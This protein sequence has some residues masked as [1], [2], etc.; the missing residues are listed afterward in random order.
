MSAH[1]ISVSTTP[2]APAAFSRGL[3]PAVLVPA[4][5]RERYH[6]MAIPLEGERGISGVFSLL[7]ECWRRMGLMKHSFEHA[8]LSDG[9]GSRE[10][11]DDR[12]RD[13]E[14]WSRMEDEGCPNAGS[15]LGANTTEPPRREPATH[16]V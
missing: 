1:N 3:K 5:P 8:E 12:H 15:Q 4:E 2:Y 16:I 9:T 6:G 13:E 7:R 10:R 14:D 11:S